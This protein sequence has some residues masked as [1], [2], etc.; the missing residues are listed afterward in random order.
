MFLGIFN[1]LM[2]LGFL[3]RVTSEAVITEEL[4]EN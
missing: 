1:A 2:A 3:G 4:M